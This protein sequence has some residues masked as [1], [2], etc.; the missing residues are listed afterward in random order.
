MKSVLFHDGWYCRHL[1][2][3]GEGIPVCIPDDA[4][5]REK[6]S[7]DALGGLNVG[8]FEG[9]DYVYTKHFTMSQEELQQHHVL[10]FEGVYRCAEVF[11]NGQK[12]G[13]RPYGYT[14]FYVEC[15]ALLKAGDNT[16]EVIAR[17]AD[18]PNSRWYSGA[19]IYRPVRL[20][21]G[22]K[23]HIELNG[24]KIRTLSLNP[25]QIE[26]SVKTSGEGKVTVEILEDGKPLASESGSTRKFVLSI[27]G[28]KTWSP[29]QPAL[30]TCRV[31]F[32][33]DEAVETFGLRTIAWGR[34]GFLINGQRV[35]LRGACVHHDNG[36]LGAACDPDA[37]ERRIRILKENGYNA[38]RSAH[39][40]CSKTALEI[41]DRLGMF[42]MDEYIDHW[43]IHKTMYDY[44]DY[45]SEWWK[46]DLTDMVEKD[47][48][49][50]CV[51]LYS[52]GNE[53]AET[54]KPRGI[55]LAGEMTEYLHGMDHTRPVTCGINIFFNFLNAIG[56]GQYS[57]EK[58]AKEAERNAKAKAEGKKTKESATGS[59][60]F[61]DL[62]GI[63][64]A[65]FMK[66]G[67]TLHGSD[68]TTR[69]AFARMDIAGYN[70]GEKRYRKDLKKYPDRLILGSE[71]FCFDAYKFW[72]LAKR[73]PRLIG[74]FVWSGIDYLGEVGI[75]SWEYGDYAPRFDNGLGWIA[76]GAGRIDLTGKPLGEALY[77]KVAFEL[78]K[79]P[80][81]A[82][83]P[84]CHEGKHSP[85]AWKM[86]NAMPS[87]SWRG[88][89]GKEA[90]VEVYARAA[91]VELMVN[92]Q[93]R[94]KKTMGKNC[95]FTFHV[96]YENGTLEAVSYDE[97]GQ[98]IGKNTLVTAG[99]ETVVQAIPEQNTVRKGHLAFVRLKY[100]DDKG[101]VKPTERGILNVS[102]SGGRLRALGSACPYYERSYLD[103]ACDTYYGEAL[104]I[105]EIQQDTTVSVESSLGTCEAK[106]LCMD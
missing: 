12:A 2:A 73:E 27:P 101:E 34:N 14:N 13:F 35:I 71:T 91:S 89:E 30:Y 79:G 51:V 11:L 56:F 49:H 44:V 69:E 81:I 25:A 78:E 23:E 70:Y 47:Y 58:A 38:L 66:I 77:T 29:E 18:Q 39:N 48:N 17:N 67:A 83:R 104:A 16:V 98:V 85:S 55:A 80:Y 102:V 61:N 8:W 53:V 60:F 76:A 6:R 86:T 54:A 93:S 9:H 10:E 82:V 50:P 90:H 64:G 72:E 33:Q 42:V 45:F 40:P 31:V 65:D 36:L 100:T 28:A 19:G 96:P 95:V 97:Q 63:L 15:D 84:L 94:G 59:K 92:G 20:W 1:D 103:S 57:D 5:L 21:S 22:E 62:A 87:W 24:V 75:G 3:S 41:C 52:T 74:D 68:V 99:T 7:A 37:L 105:V 43:Y 46:Q 88:C 106:I 26:V 32:G 4:M